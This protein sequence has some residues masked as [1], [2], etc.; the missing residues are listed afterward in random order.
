MDTPPHYS[1][2][3]DSL[4]GVNGPLRIIA[5]DGHRLSSQLFSKQLCS[6]LRLGPISHPYAL[7]ASLGPE[8]LSQ[9]LRNNDSARHALEKQ[10]AAADPKA[11]GMTYCVATER[12]R[13]DVEKVER[14]VCLSSFNSTHVDTA[15]AVCSC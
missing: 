7:A 3:T 2:I 9:R 12:L 6:H 13:K 4:N 14:A 5:F 15:T 8:N 11:A 10:T 1:P